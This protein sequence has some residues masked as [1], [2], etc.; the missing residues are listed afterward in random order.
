MQTVVLNSNFLYVIGGC[1]SQC[2]HGESAVNSVHRYDPRLNT[3][4][5]VKSML[6]KRSYFYAC[7]VNVS[8]KADGFSNAD[9]KGNEKQFIYAIGGKNREGALS[10][11]ERYD[12]ST[13]SW[14]FVSSLPSAYY[15]HSGCVLK[16]VIYISGN[17][18]FYS[19]FR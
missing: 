14:E 1:T 18:K 16:D 13:N 2:A 7:V 8:E 11:V 4:I 9:R 10:S 12:L 17:Y 5:N 3:W 15:A 19:I 6:T